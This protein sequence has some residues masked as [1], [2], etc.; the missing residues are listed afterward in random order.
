M[1]RLPRILLNATTLLALMLCLMVTAAIIVQWARSRRG[2]EVISRSSVRVEPDRII[3]INRR[4]WSTPGTLDLDWNEET[5]DTSGY[6]SIGTVPREAWFHRRDDGDF[7][8]L[9]RT[10]GDAP[11]WLV[12]AGLNWS[13][14]SSTGAGPKDRRHF[15]WVQVRFSFL[16]PTAIATTIVPSM[17][18]WRIIR[19]IRRRRAGLCLTCGYDLRAT[20]DRCPECGTIPSR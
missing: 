4:A 15:F 11:A 19:R 10:G 7:G 8:R 20:P 18:G 9:E 3:M 1:K 6:A 12:R 2:G 17:A 13:S 14:G 5:I 16:L